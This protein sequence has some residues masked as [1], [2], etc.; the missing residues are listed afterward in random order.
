MLKIAVFTVNPLQEN[1]YV[2]YEPQGECLVVDPGC[3]SSAEDS[4]IIQFIEQ[5]NLSLK[6]V[7][8]THG[9]VDHIAGVNA[10]KQHFGVPFAASRRD[11]QIIDMAPQ[12][13]NM[14]GFDLEAAPVV[15]INLDEISEIKL[16]ES[17]VEIVATPGH[18]QGQVTFWLPNEKVILPGDTLFRE[19]IGRS[20][21]PGGDYSQLMDSIINK[22]LPLGDNVQV[23]PGHGP[24]TTIGHETLYNPF[25]VE[26]IRGDVKYQ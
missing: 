6:M 7:I 11:Q 12:Y 15:D 5:N 24:A 17:R 4:R 26:V 13:A 18:S 22:I 14:F 9:H 21:L 20:D 25:I 19:S 23:L 8:A 16:G 3:V 1:A 10:I 2:V